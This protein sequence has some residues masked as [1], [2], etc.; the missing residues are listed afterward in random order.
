MM[1][2]FSSGQISFYV[3]F[4][5]RNFGTGAHVE[6]SADACILRVLLYRGSSTE[7]SELSFVIT[8]IA[9][10]PYFDREWVLL[11]IPIERHRRDASTMID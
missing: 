7:Q 11:P 3:E 8:V 2:A 10:C 6:C 4:T 1:S 5:F 9:P